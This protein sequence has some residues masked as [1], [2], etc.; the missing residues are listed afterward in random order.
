MIYSCGSHHTDD[1]GQGD[2]LEPIYKS[3]LQ[4]QDIIWKTYRERETIGTSYGIGSGKSMLA[5][6]HDHDHDDDVTLCTRVV[7]VLVLHI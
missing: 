6:R 2:Q 5:A 7:N 3:S 4:I 1:Q